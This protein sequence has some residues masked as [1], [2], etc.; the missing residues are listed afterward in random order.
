MD[1]AMFKLSLRE[2][3]VLVTLAAV[4]VAW[5][6]DH[7]HQA[8]RHLDAEARAKASEAALESEELKVQIQNAK[9]YIDYRDAC[10]AHA[11]HVRGTGKKARLAYVGSFGNGGGE[12]FKLPE[13]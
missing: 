8:K 11:L 12:D 9:I 7:A 6:L 13:R 5:W 4:G 2:L 3:F 10:A 1:T